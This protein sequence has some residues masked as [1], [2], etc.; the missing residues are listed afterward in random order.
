[1][2]DGLRRNESGVEVHAFDLGVDCRY[3]ER[4]PCRFYDSGIV[5]RADD[6][7]GRAI[8]ARTDAFDQRT[9][10]E[11]GNCLNWQENEARSAAHCDA[12]R[13]MSPRFAVW[14]G[15]MNLR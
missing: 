11:V 9:F 2:P 7:P 4:P 1:V 15:R 8:G 6:N 3:I 12:G 13:R 5:A 10:A 14:G